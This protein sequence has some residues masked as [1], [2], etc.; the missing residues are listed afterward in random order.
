MTSETPD[1]TSTKT[2]LPRTSDFLSFTEASA[3][4]G[5]A[6][7]LATKLTGRAHT[8]PHFPKY[9]VEDENSPFP[10][11]L[12]FFHKTDA[13]FSY[14]NTSKLCAFCCADVL[15]EGYN[16][17]SMFATNSH[18]PQNDLPD[19][20]W[21]EMPTSGEFY[22]PAFQAG[23]EDFAGG[24]AKKLS[25]SAPITMATLIASEPARISIPRV[26]G[27]MEA[28]EWLE[29][30]AKP[31]YIDQLHLTKGWSPLA[32]KNAAIDA[33]ISSE[34]ATTF[35]MSVLTK[36]KK[37]GRT[38]T[39]QK[40]DPV[41]VKVDPPPYSEVISVEMSTESNPPDVFELE[42]P[43][44]TQEPEAKSLSETLYVGT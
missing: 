2:D 30:Q 31:F 9:R 12:G 26:A 43:T 17:W 19:R 14:L 24:P 35:D 10:S 6:E 36:P 4:R 34:T 40:N 39:R 5:S 22:P 16:A 25:N 32:E 28:W 33:A 37:Y 41:I 15:P 8:C 7:Y 44:Q 3:I 38:I 27:A 11:R 21:L 42:S 13:N 23:T 18:D 29:A 1:P 20:R